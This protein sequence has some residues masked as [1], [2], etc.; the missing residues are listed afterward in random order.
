MLNGGTRSVLVP[1]FDERSYAHGPTLFNAVA[2]FL[3]DA[4]AV[5]FKINKIISSNNLYLT[6]MELPKV[7]SIRCAAECS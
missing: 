2:P 4:S 1:V 5:S 3:G 7:T 6:Y